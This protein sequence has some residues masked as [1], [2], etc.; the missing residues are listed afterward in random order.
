[1]ANSFLLLKKIVIK[2]N[3]YRYYII[4]FV[5]SLIFTKYYFLLTNEY[6][7]PAYSERIADFVADKVFQKRFLIPVTANLLSSVTFLNF[8]QS[9]KLLTLTSTC[10]LL[11]SFSSL[12]RTLSKA[13]HSPYLG[14][15]VLLPVGWN[16]LIL[17]SIFHAYDIPTLAFF[18]LGLLLFIRKKYISFYILY[19]LATLNRESTC[20]ITISVFLLLYKL[21]SSDTTFSSLKRNIVLIKQCFLQFVIWILIT[22]LISIAIIKNPGN[23]YEDT[24][25]MLQF[26]INMWEGNKSWPYLNTDFFF[27]NPRC[28]LTLFAC[29]WIFIPFLWNKIEIQFKKLLLLIPIFFVPALLYANLMESRVYHELNI[30]LTLALLSGLINSVPSE[31]HG[32]LRR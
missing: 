22:N 7:P 19:I 18:T 2:F 12:L 28:F 16:Y 9:L 6:Y 24:F 11:L 26:L 23:H 32:F 17:N 14:I 8:D 1:M 21:D 25:S 4:I 20:F 5:V 31:R 27:H 10:V 30:V 29:I 13:K 3:Q 15:L